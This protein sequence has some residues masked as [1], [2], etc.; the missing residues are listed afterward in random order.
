MEDGKNVQINVIRYTSSAENRIF[1]TLEM[2]N[3]KQVYTTIALSY[4]Y[5]T[6][7]NVIIYWLYFQQHSYF[8]CMHMRSAKRN[9]YMTWLYNYLVY[10]INGFQMIQNTKMKAT[11]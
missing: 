3:T 4:F 1:G 10:Y 5:C 9:C 8:N 11:P 2:K 7:I 6:E